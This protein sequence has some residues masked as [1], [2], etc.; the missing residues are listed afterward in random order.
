MA[1][2]AHWADLDEA[3]DS[4][5]RAR[6]GVMLAANVGMMGFAQSLLATMLIELCVWGIISPP[7]VQKLCKA[8][9]HDGFL[10]PEIEFLAQLGTSGTYENNARRD[11]F[12]KLG[13]RV[14]MPKRLY[15][16]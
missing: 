11:L 1:H 10:H 15:V 4:F 14:A 9:E 12:R 3:L 2:P 16:N 13:R 8:A 7:F 5:R 6:S